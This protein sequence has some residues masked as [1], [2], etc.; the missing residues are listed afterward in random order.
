MFL[1][2]SET[3]DKVTTLQ[4]HAVVC[5]LS[6]LGYLVVALNTA[7]QSLLVTGDNGVVGG[8]NPAPLIRVFNNMLMHHSLA[9]RLV[10]N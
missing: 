5:G 9:V 2:E 1:E 6:Q 4:Q 7:V 8:D 10:F 3:K